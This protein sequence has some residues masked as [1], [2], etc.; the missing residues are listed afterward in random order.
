MYVQTPPPEPTGRKHSKRSST[1]QFSL[2]GR[3]RPSTKTD[4]EGNRVRKRKP[5]L[6]KRTMDSFGS[7]EGIDLTNLYAGGGIDIASSV[8]KRARLS[9]DSGSGASPPAMMPQCRGD[10]ME[11]RPAPAG[12]KL[13]PSLKS[14]SGKGSKSKKKPSLKEPSMSR[15]APPPVDIVEPLPSEGDPFLAR[16]RAAHFLYYQ[17]VE[18]NPEGGEDA[19][20]AAGKVNCVVYEGEMMD[21]YREGMGICL[22]GND[23]MYEGQWKKNK[24]VSVCAEGVLLLSCAAIFITS[25][26]SLFY[27]PSMAKELS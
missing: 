21:G 2:A 20:P 12:P 7:F 4:G 9:G 1:G 16:W 8:K 5:S 24:E 22:Y 19:A 18:T 23:T 11:A 26:F 3:G 13:V 10:T 14:S 17:L 25:F 27:H 15:F 6:K